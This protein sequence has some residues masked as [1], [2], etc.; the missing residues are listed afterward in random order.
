MAIQIAKAYGAATIVT[1]TSGADNIAFVKSLGAGR[2]PAR[3]PR[4]LPP[5]PRDSALRSC[6][7]LLRAAQRE[8]SWLTRAP[9]GH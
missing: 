6:V 7:P 9:R 8:K 3:A 2:G 1:S 5:L 4:R